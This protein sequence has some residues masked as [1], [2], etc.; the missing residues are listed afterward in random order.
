MRIDW[1][2]FWLRWVFEIN[3]SINSLSKNSN[4]RGLYSWKTTIEIFILPYIQQALSMNQIKCKLFIGLWNFTKEMTEICDYLCLYNANVLM[5]MSLIKE[6]I[7]SH[8]K[9]LSSKLKSMQ[10]YVVIIINFS[11]FIR[12]HNFQ[13]TC[14]YFL[15]L[16][17]YNK[18]TV[19]TL[20]KTRFFIWFF[21][22]FVFLAKIKEKLIW[23]FNIFNVYN[24][25]SHT[26]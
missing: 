3:W 25:L 10:N 18:K 17:T 20:K 1:M 23:I 4:A 14:H 21:Y 5:F 2:K 6:I 9:S 24:H 11:I 13:W 12:L 22:C 15:T 16:Y 26:I 8:Y 7:I 19:E